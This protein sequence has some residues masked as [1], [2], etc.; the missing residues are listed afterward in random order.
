MRKA[1][2]TFPVG[3]TGRAT[4]RCSLVTPRPRLPFPLV[5]PSGT[6][7][8]LVVAR[9]VAPRQTT[10]ARPALERHRTGTLFP[11]RTL[12]LDAPLTAALT[13]PMQLLPCPAAR[14]SSMHPKRSR[15]DPSTTVV[16]G[17]GPRR[18]SRRCT[19]KAISGA[20]GQG[21]RDRALAPRC[22]SGAAREPC[23]QACPPRRTGFGHSTDTL[24]TGFVPRARCACVEVG[25]AWVGDAF[26]LSGGEVS[27][28]RRCA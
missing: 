21:R 27:G 16:V 24:R 12:S 9:R 3:D 4:S 17:E 11:L 25:R 5:V 14:A 19:P 13:R 7:A 1:A 2:M 15:R 23:P 10:L 18:R 22:L 28:W 6:C 20:A 26:V 8:H